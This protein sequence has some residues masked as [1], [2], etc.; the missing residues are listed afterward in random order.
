MERDGINVFMAVILLSGQMAGVGVLALPSSMIHT[1][2]AGFFLI[3]Y[4]TLNAIFVGRKLGVCWLLIEEMFPEFRNEKRQ[5]EE[6]QDIS[7]LEAFVSLYL[8]LLAL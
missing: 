8:D 1:G 3:V 7:S 6:L 5:Q 2:P 4:F